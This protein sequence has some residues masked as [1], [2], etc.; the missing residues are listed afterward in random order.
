[1]NTLYWV[2]A[3]GLGTVI[4]I[5][6]YCYNIDRLE[7]DPNDDDYDNFEENINENKQPQTA[8]IQNDKNTNNRELGDGC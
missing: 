7:E 1:M 6:V 3:I 5:V 4:V 8:L 2:L